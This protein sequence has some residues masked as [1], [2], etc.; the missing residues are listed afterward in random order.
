MVS[1]MLEDVDVLISMSSDLPA[2]NVRVC[3]SDFEVLIG[4]DEY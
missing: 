4:V 1:L 3:A 2:F